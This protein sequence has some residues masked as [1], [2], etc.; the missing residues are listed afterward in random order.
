MASALNCKAKAAQSICGTSVRRNKSR[1]EN[2][3]PATKNTNSF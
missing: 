1:H 2:S 3:M